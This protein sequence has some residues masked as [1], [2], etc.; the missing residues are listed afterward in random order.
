M[1]WPRKYYGAIKK[2]E[3]V[4]PE[5]IKATYE[6]ELNLMETKNS[7]FYF[8]EEYGQAP[9]D[10]IEKYCKHSKGKWMG[11]PVK[12]ELFQKAKL[13][14]VFGWLEKGTNLRR[15]REVGDVRGR[16]CGKSTETAGV[17]EYMLIGDGEGGPEIYCV[18]NKLDQAKIIFNECVNMRAQSPEIKEVTNKRQSD[19]YCHLN[20][21]F[22]KAIASDTKTMDG[23]NASFFSLDE[24]HEARTRDLYDLMVQSQS[25]REQPLAWLI[26]TLGFFRGGFCDSQIDYY[27]DIAMGVIDE[28]RVLPLLYW[29]NKK[30]DWKDRACWAMANP[31]LG[32]IKKYET[33]ETYVKRA[34]EDASFLPTLLTKDFN[35][36][37]TNNS[38]WLSFDAI[39]NESIMD[40]DRL[41]NSYAI[42]GCDLS[43]TTDLTCAT[44]MIRKPED[45]K[46]YVLQ[47]YFLPQSRID[48]I[49]K[50]KS[51]EAPYKL[52]AEQGHLTIC[53]GARVDYHAV[54]EWFVRMI[55]EYNIRPLWVCYDRALSGYWVPEMVGYGFDMEDIPQ[56]AKTWTYP[57]KQMGAA[58]E[59]HLI[60]YQNNPVLRWC[61]SNT[62]KKSQNTD[63]IESIQPVRISSNRRIDGMVSLL[64]AWVGYCRHYEEYMS[65]V[66]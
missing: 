54:T 37:E 3:E 15:I 28:P 1:N 21:G 2:G 33:L 44:L 25:T 63:G 17:I 22:I 31:G 29:L 26:S 41:K 47:Q 9:I 66:K 48:Y 8:N 12:L 39:V 57:M 51:K 24:W 19:I 60:V 58:F 36:P 34:K 20:M 49:N 18:A 30:E 56:G 55:K 35:I 7:D 4:V 10:F 23:L 64:N 46:V 5:T 45:A 52:W 65:Y 38:A 6:R 42:G 11:K 14:L 43:A 53:E 50:A 59:D 62:G 32:M 27:R 16:K 13:Q 40:M 61:L